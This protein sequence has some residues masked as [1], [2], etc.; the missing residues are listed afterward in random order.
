MKVFAQK[1]V[2]VQADFVAATTFPP[3]GWWR[4]PMNK[5]AVFVD[6]TDVVAQFLTEQDGWQRNQTEEVL[7]RAGWSGR[8]PLPLFYGVR[9][10]IWDG[11]TFG[12]GG[13]IDVEAYAIDA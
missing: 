12:P 1:A 11:T 10:R 2:A 6:S 4:D 3:Q 7:F 5:L 8:D 9:F 13:H